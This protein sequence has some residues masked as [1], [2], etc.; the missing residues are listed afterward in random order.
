MCRA[1]PQARPKSV[2][3]RRS[4]RS[5]AHGCHVPSRASATRAQAS[6]P[7]SAASGVRGR[8]GRAAG[9]ALTAPIGC[10]PV[11]VTRGASRQ[12]NAGQEWVSIRADRVEAVGAEVI[13]DE[14][15][16]LVAWEQDADF[17]DP[18]H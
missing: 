11:G 13:D 15:D 14:P 7:V 1:G 9:A 18:V 8:E 17:V 12:P 4:R 10:L 3:S 5:V 6:R 2:R 16:E